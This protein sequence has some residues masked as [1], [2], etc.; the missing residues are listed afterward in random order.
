MK[1][2]TLLLSSA[3]LV[4]AGSAYAADLP[5]KKGAPAAKA[6]TG[7][8]AFG[9]GF[10]Q[11]PGGDNCIKITGYQAYAGQY[12]ST[13]TYAQNVDARLLFDVRSNSD[14]GV[15]RG[16]TRLNFGAGTGGSSYTVGRVY[17]SVGSLTVGKYGTLAD[18]AG[19]S[20]WMYGSKL[21]GGTGVGIN[22]AA[23]IGSGTLTVGVENAANYSGTAKRPDVLAKYTMSAG[24]ANFTFVG[25]SHEANI[26]AGS[27]AGY[28]GLARVGVTAGDFGA[29]VYGGG[30]SAALAYTGNLAGAGAVDADYDGTNSSTGSHIGGELT[31]KLGGGTLALAAEQVEAKIN[32]SKDT[33]QQYGAYYSFPI[34]K[35]ISID[36]EYIMQTSSA[37][38]SNTFYLTIHRDF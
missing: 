25:V 9:A 8:P 38:S 14:A 28:A 18:I 36:P 27:T 37:T 35:G 32:T 30:S 15:V 21:G 6:A 19:T 17:A 26:A 24:A 3:A 5:A 7:C 4:V 33:F 1:L 11:I 10:F 22:Y 12:D 13:G 23:S 29:A 2:S 31:A 16:V 20:A 34:A